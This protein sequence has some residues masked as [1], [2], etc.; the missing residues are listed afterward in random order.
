MQCV[1]AAM[2][3]EHEFAK[4]PAS[5]VCFLRLQMLANVSVR[6]CI[7]QYKCIHTVRRVD[8]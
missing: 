5:A 1:V 4:W 7:G 2:S 3:L 8:K 6:G